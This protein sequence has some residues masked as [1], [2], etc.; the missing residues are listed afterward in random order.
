MGRAASGS[1]LAALLPILYFSFG[2]SVAGG[3]RAHL[4]VARGAGGLK[5]RAGNYRAQP[6][7]ATLPLLTGG[8]QLE[9]YGGAANLV[10]SGLHGG[11]LHV[12]GHHGGPLL[13]Q[14]RR[15]SSVS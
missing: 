8:S 7:L 10:S 4:N 15:P 1:K 3:V 5:G 6:A 13:P 9:R 14:P 2:L 12:G 11:P